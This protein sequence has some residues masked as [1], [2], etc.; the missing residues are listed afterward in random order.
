MT[1]PNLA[2]T[3]FGSH[4]IEQIL[5]A[6]TELGKPADKIVQSLDHAEWELENG[7]MFDKGG[8][9]VASPCSWVFRSLAKTGYYRKP[10]GY[11]SPEEQALID[12]EETA[13][14][15]LT[16]RQRA[17]QAQFEAWRAGLTPQDLEAAMV[18]FVGG[19]KEQ[20]LKAHWIKK[21]RSNNTGSL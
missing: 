11:V 3:G 13:K 14:T 4:Q 7:R 8:A 5:Q 19:P 16:I 9:P 12:T 10:K 17:E 15:L 1:W 21:Y 2:T 20:W 6:L 18:G